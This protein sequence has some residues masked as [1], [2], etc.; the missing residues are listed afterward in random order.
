MPLGDAYRSARLGARPRP[1][2]CQTC[3]TLVT[4][5]YKRRGDRATVAKPCRV[6]IKFCRLM[7]IARC[8]GAY[9]SGYVGMARATISVP[10]AARSPR[11][12]P[13]SVRGA[14]DSLC[15]SCGRPSVG[16][17]RRSGRSSVWICLGNALGRRRLRLSPPLMPPPIW[18]DQAFWIFSNDRRL[19]FCHVYVF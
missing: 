17:P 19:L 3:A 10:N 6:I 1:G 2:P 5:T 18:A 12:R 8:R 16:R 13:P 15:A 14:S 7:M 4:R 9:S 11:L